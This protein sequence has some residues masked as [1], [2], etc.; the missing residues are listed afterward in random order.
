MTKL[1]VYRLAI[2]YVAWV[3]E[4]SEKAQRTISIPIA[5]PIPIPIYRE[6]TGFTE[7]IP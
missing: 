4:K 5:I 7:Y 1:D 3:F 6:P 2:G